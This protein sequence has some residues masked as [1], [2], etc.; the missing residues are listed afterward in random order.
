V[1][2]AIQFYD[3]FSFQVRK[4]QDVVT[5][6]MLPSELASFQLPI[7]QVLPESVFGIGWSVP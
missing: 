4:I 1:L 7:P 5:K 3:D 2:V 6:W